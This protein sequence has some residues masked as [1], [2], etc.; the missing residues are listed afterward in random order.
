MKYSTSPIA[1]DIPLWHQSSNLRGLFR[2]SLFF[3]SRSFRYPGIS[4]SSMTGICYSSG[5]L[6]SS[7]STRPVN[8]LYISLCS[9]IMWKLLCPMLPKEFMAT[10]GATA[11]MLQTNLPSVPSSDP[12]PLVSLDIL[13]NIRLA[14]DL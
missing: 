5:L 12:V 11:R 13:R 3:Q 9:L 2:V 10:Y 14:S 4:S 7:L 1:F 6:P 8:A